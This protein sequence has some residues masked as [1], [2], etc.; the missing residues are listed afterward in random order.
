MFLD[1]SSNG[2]VECGNVSA[3]TGAGCNS[4]EN[5]IPKRK[6]LIKGIEIK[7]LFIKLRASH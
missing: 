7:Y 4:S 5:R 1:A 2:P 3:P 6:K